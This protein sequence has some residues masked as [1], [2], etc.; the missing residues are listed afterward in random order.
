MSVSKDL[1]LNTTPVL[2]FA[3][4]YCPSTC[5]DV[6]YCCEHETKDTARQTASLAKRKKETCCLYCL[7]DLLFVSLC[8]WF[9]FCDNIKTSAQVSFTA[10]LLCLAVNETCCLR[11]SLF[12]QKRNQRY[13]ET[14]SKSQNRKSDLAIP[15]LFTRVAKRVLGIFFFLPQY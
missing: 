11:D 3:R 6:S 15:C 12:V 10:S 5:V 13:G 14:N 1:P 8:L 2:F 9:R 7:R 4:S